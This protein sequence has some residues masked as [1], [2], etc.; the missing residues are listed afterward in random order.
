ML[1]L[2]ALIFALIVGVVVGAVL[3]R[4][5]I[6]QPGYKTRWQGALRVVEA[7]EMENRD[8]RSGIL[9]HAARSENASASKRLLRDIQRE[10]MLHLARER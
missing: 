3:T 5:L 9:N 8:L 2:A 1:A 10:A 4:R 6:T 7:L